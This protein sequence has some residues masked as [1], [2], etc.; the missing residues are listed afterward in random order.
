LRKVKRGQGLE[1]NNTIKMDLK[2]KYWK[3]EC[4]RHL[5]TIYQT[6]INTKHLSEKKLIDF[7]RL[8]M[9]KYALS[10]DEILE[11]YIQL[12]FK[13]S[14]NYINITR[15]SSKLNEPL[16]INYMAQVGD[17]SISAWLSD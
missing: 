6:K 15:T 11:H 9:S 13:T 10:D 3:I 12:P 4:T 17:I 16:N 8:L 14:K 1:K 5:S 2:T 7:I